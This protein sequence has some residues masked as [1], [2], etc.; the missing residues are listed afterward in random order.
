MDTAHAIQRNRNINSAKVIHRMLAK[1]GIHCEEYG[2][3][4]LAGEKVLLCTSKG[5]L[6]LTQGDFTP[7]TNPQHIEDHMRSSST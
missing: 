4:L 1:K 6:L 3:F 5:A 2:P 7:A